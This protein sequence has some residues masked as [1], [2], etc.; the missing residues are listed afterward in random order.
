MGEASSSSATPRQCAC[1]A[2]PHSEMA[3]LGFAET[4]MHLRGSAQPKGVLQGQ[5][6]GVKARREGAQAGRHSPRAFIVLPCRR[7]HHALKPHATALAL[8]RQLLRSRVSANPVAAHFTRAY[9]PLTCDGTP[10]CAAQVPITAADGNSSQGMSEVERARM[11]MASV[12]YVGRP[13]R[14]SRQ[15]HVHW[16]RSCAA[17][18][19]GLVHVAAGTG[20]MR[21]GTAAELGVQAVLEWGPLQGIIG[22]R[23]QRKTAGPGGP[24]EGGDGQESSLISD[25]AEH[26]SNY[27][28]LGAAGGNTWQASVAQQRIRN[29]LPTYY[30]LYNGQCSANGSSITT[31]SECISA[32]NEVGLSYGMSYQTGSVNALD[33]PGCVRTPNGNLGIFP[34]GHTASCSSRNQRTCICKYDS[35]PPPSAPPPPSPSPPPPSP[36]PPPSSPPQ[37]PTPPPIKR[38]L[39]SGQAEKKGL[40]SKHDLRMISHRHH[41]HEHLPHH[42]GIRALTTHTHTPHTHYAPPPWSPPPSLPPTSPGGMYRTSLTG[43]FDV[44]MA[45]PDSFF[46]TFDRSA[47]RSSMRAAFPNVTDDVVI[48]QLTPHVGSLIVRYKMHFADDHGALEAQQRIHSITNWPSVTWLGSMKIVHGSATVVRAALMRAPS[49]PPP[50]PP[51][52][53]PPPPLPPPPP[54]PYAPV[55]CDIPVPISDRTSLPDLPCQTITPYPTP[56]L[57]TACDA[58]S[59]CLLGADEG[60]VQPPALAPPPPAPPIASCPSVP[61]SSASQPATIVLNPS[62]P[63]QYAASRYA[64]LTVL[65]LSD[66]K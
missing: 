47:F 2:Q 19:I 22:T 23:Q 6:C 42:P 65:T 5:V 55:S 25:G 49:P 45:D 41:P 27:K 10:L 51:P 43:E 37:S 30:I 3:I 44:L 35:S 66:Q 59:F 1:N 4:Q 34:L 63:E 62:F 48:Q 9:P 20:E 39:I 26:A 31:L 17:I 46:A 15:L 21:E 52:P 12:H 33:P 14:S 18:F 54:P 32:A 61:L 13:L 57:C 28:I 8:V 36:S 38:E 7:P 50:S 56:P 29:Q 53:S 16:S 24:G 60:V 40:S 58:N 11:T 64:I